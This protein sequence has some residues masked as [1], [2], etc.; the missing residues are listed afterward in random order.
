MR[1]NL[2]YFILV[3]SLLGCKG[4]TDQTIQQDQPLYPKPIIVS[5]NTT[6]GYLINRLTGDSIKPLINSFGDTIKTG[7][8][9]PFKGVVVKNCS[10]C[11]RNKNNDSR[12]CS[13]CA[14][15]I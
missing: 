2:I 12:Q 14:G 11:C 3:F 4:K 10:D 5:L 1:V 8:L 13:S 6:D 15:S 7:V 9:I